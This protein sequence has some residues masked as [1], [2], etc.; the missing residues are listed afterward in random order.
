MVWRLAQDHVAKDLI[1]AIKSK[2]ISALVRVGKNDELIIKQVMDAGADGIIVPM[3]NNSKDAQ[4][5]VNFVKYPPE[6][7][8]GVGLSQAQNYGIGFEEYKEWLKSESVIIAQIERFNFI[9][10]VVRLLI[11][12]L[13]FVWYTFA[14]RFRFKNP[15]SF[16]FISFF[17]NF[18]F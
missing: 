13:I 16:R 12:V 11:M 2:N 5:A 3:V 9:L 8:R 6:G 10:W 18:Q 4:N 14:N 7:L 15:F 17:L 1:S